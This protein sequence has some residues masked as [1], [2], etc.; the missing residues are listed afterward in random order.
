MTPQSMPDIVRETFPHGWRKL[1]LYAG[2]LADEGEKRGLIGPREL[3]RLWSR[4]I[5][6]CTAINNFIPTDV[7]VADVGSGAGLPGIVLAVTRPDLR[8][9]LIEPMERR[10]EWLAEIVEILDLPHVDIV[11]ARAEEIHGH[12]T[13]DIVTARAVAALDKLMRLTMPLINGG[14]ALIA[15]KGERAQQEV[16]TSV[17]VQRKFRVKSCE[18]HTVPALIA[19]EQPTRVVVATRY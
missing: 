2:L 19:D 12:N 17:K 16:D 14:G 9:T 1:D 5:L 8:I 7:R 15:L 6:N 3:P 18:V 11:R 13:F 10:I 4:H